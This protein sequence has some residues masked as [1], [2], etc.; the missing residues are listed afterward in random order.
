[1]AI[2][3]EKILRED[4]NTGEDQLEGIKVS[5]WCARV[6]AGAKWRTGVGET[7]A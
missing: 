1:M 3:S 5:S 4:I 2:I 6:S 7:D